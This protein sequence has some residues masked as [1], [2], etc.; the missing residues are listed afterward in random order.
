MG[1]NMNTTLRSLLEKAESLKK[2]FDAL[3]PLKPED[4]ARLWKK[5]RLEW[6]FNSNHI[7][8]NTLTY[9]ETELLLIFEKTAGDHD[10]RELE[11]MKAHDVA[12]NLIR[13][14]ATDEKYEIN[15]RDI[16]RLN[17]TILVRPFY[18]SA[19][20]L[21]GQETRRTIQVGE[22]KQQPNSVELPNGE[23][24][25]YASPI[26]TPGRMGDL[27]DWYN[28]E[29]NMSPIILAAELHYRFIR[30]HPFDDGN[31]RVARLLMN[32]G[33]MREGY[34]PIVIKSTEK[35]R[36]LNA[37]Q[38][39][40]ADI[41]DPFYEFVT[42][43]LI[44]SLE[45]AIKASKGEP[46]D[47]KDDAA[48]RFELLKRQLKSVDPEKTI[49][50]RFNKELYVDLLQSW[51]FQLI[52]VV[53]TKLLQF[54]ELFSKASYNLSIARQY[55]NEIDINSL[56]GKLLDILVNVQLDKQE[57]QANYATIVLNVFYGGFLTAGTD[58]FNANQGFSIAFEDTK[59]EISFQ[60]YSVAVGFSNA[61]LF[62][63]L[64]HQP[65]SLE[66]MEMV[67]SRIFH[68]M[69]EYLEYQVAVKG[70]K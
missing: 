54:D 11:E 7:E 2:E 26:E 3:Q 57:L 63:R 41:F 23:M 36:Y 30:I 44:W 22:Y 68:A 62:R 15:Q 24:F 46:I 1:E 18:K 61:V 70:I 14:W 6:S 66:D 17:E 65:L 16:K 20:T 4:E 9:S 28:T 13:S 51:A 50:K 53:T 29:T 56:E 31:G 10:L 39:A 5:L 60:E 40:D 34:P 25:H 42:E 48:K 49:Q 52:R 38:R 21:D 8:G 67:A 47:E 59:Y 33:L 58:A 43:Q 69:V 27:V 19:R 55:G 32:L 35:K 64:L 12:V 45:L 37:L